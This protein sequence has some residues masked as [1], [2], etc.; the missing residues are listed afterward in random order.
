MGEFLYPTGYLT[1]QPEL[2][3]S[4]VNG[5]GPGNWKLDLVPDELLGVE[6]DEPCNIHDYEY[7][8]GQDKISADARLHANILIACQLQ[9][10]HRI[11][12]LLPLA[13]AY[14][15]AVAKAGGSHFG[16]QS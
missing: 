13:N 2:K 9:H 8:L 4:I 6:I 10:P 3:R 5:C 1:L 16:A 15:L 11:A 12:L 7:W 14:Y